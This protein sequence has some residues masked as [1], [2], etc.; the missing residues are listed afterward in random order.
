MDCIVTFYTQSGAFKFERLLKQEGISVTLMP[1]PR[2]LSSSCGIAARTEL[3]G[4]VKGYIT[5]EVDGIY[6]AADHK[7]IYKSE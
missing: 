3:P 2:R 7:M 6:S 4:D 1:V 5:D